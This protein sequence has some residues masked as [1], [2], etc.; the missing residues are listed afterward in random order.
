MRYT[1]AISSDWEYDK[2]FVLV[3]LKEVVHEVRVQEGLD[4]TSDERSPYYVLPPEDP[5][6]LIQYQ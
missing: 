5:L 4:D 1:K 2:L 3:G 6:Y